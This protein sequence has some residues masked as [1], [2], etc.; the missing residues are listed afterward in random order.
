[1]TTVQLIVR[2]STFSLSHP[3]AETDFAETFVV[4]FTPTNGNGPGSFSRLLHDRYSN[5]VI[6][7]C[8]D[9]RVRLP[10]SSH[11]VD[12]MNEVH[13]HLVMIKLVGS[14]P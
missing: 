3:N 12:L 13:P 10:T 6:L 1:M 5:A 9:R 2:S 8:E 7:R 4:K 14:R 11:I